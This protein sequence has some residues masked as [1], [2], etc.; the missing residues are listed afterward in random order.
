MTQWSFI[1]NHARALLFIAGHPDARLRDLAAA[2]DVTERNAY[3]IVTD[4]VTSGY[5]IK[6]REGRRNRYHIQDH[7][8]MRDTIGRE[9]T[10]GEV[11]DLLADRGSPSDGSATATT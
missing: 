6:E 11:L 2:L 3:G 7:L 5:V 1:T 4:L 8:P 10:I 9:L